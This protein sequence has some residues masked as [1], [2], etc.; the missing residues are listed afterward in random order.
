MGYRLL[1]LP[2]VTDR[3][4]QS[5]SRLYA[6]IAKGLFVRPIA[7]SPRTVAWPEHEID[8]LIAARIRGVSQEELSLLVDQLHTLR[9]SVGLNAKDHQ[10]VSV[11][12][13]T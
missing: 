11:I 5:R 9:S 7:L 3:T 8:Q 1:R 6:L 4:G 2:A 13:S 10:E 12:T